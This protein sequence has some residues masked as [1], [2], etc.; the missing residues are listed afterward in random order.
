MTVSGVQLAR[1]YR[2]IGLTVSA[3]T[4]SMH[5]QRT[6]SNTVNQT[7]NPLIVLER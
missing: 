2:Q 5:R 1:R 3:A 4:N 7:L 6:V